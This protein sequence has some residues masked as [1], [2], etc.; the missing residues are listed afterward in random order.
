MIRVIDSHVKRYHVRILI[1]ASYDDSPM[2]AHPKSTQYKSPSVAVLDMGFSIV[3]KY[4]DNWTHDPDTKKYHRYGWYVFGDLT[5]AIL[6]YMMT[7][8]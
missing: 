6:F 5:E 8:K 1:V 4:F 3:Y 2:L 7:G